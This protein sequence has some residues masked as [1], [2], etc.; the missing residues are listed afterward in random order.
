[1]YKSTKDVALSQEKRVL[2]TITSYMLCGF[3][4]RIGYKYQTSKKE[5][6]ISELLPTAKAIHF[7]NESQKCFEKYAD[8][9]TWE[10][11]RIVENTTANTFFSRDDQI[12]WIT[13]LDNF[14]LVFAEIE[15]CYLYGSPEHKEI[16]KKFHALCKDIR[17]IEADNTLQ[18]KDFKMFPRLSF[19]YIPQMLDLNN[20]EV[21]ALLPYL[22]AAYVFNFRKEHLFFG[23]TELVKLIFSESNISTSEAPKIRGRIKDL[24]KI[25]TLSGN[26]EDLVCFQTDRPSPSLYPADENNHRLTKGKLGTQCVR[27][28]SVFRDAFKEW[29]EI[30]PKCAELAG[31]TKLEQ[32]LDIATCQFLLDYHISQETSRR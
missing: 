11:H 9:L 31:F 15:K 8:R 24:A 12:A 17:K 26:M 5:T 6:E 1:M 27:F 28:E 29:C 4:A 3:N 13:P 16:K 22:L 23:E 10:S 14:K 25:F 20:E 32:N 30:I 18:H 19:T 7:W 2:R 21:L